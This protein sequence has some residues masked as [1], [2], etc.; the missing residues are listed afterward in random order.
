MKVQ[1]VLEEQEYN[2]LLKYKEY[3]EKN[4][5]KVV[6]GNYQVIG[7]MYE[8][9]NLEKVLAEAAENKLKGGIQIFGLTDKAINFKMNEI[10]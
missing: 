2:E 3:Y 7:S 4:Y 5:V 10:N 6:Y 9:Y 8:P 1:V